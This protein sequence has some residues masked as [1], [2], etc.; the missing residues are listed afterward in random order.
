[1]KRRTFN[2]GLQASL[3]SLGLAPIQSMQATTYSLK[4]PAAL[5]PGDKVGLIAPAGPVA[6]E[7]VANAITN[8][9]NLGLEPVY[10]EIALKNMAIFL[11]VIK[12]DSTTST[13]CLPIKK[14]RASGA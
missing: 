7:K 1:M 6:P 8:M 2:K 14:S 9:Q 5:N 13:K 11:P 12:S 10:N 4:T 3:L